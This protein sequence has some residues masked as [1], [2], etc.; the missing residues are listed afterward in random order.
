VSTEF[1]GCEGAGA[2]SW[3]NV[4]QIASG[5]AAGDV[6]LADLNGDKKADYIVVDPAS[7]ATQAWL[8][9]G[10]NPAGGQ[11]IWLPQ[12]TIA[13]GAGLAN[14]RVAFADINADGRADYLAI[15]PDASVD[16]WLNGGRAGSAGR[17]WFWSSQGRIAGSYGPSFETSA[18]GDINGDGRADYLVV[19]LTV[20]MYAYL[21]NGGDTGVIAAH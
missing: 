4:G 20:F 9:G 13:S 10:P 14:K 21:M 5:G 19:D 3:Q 8:N 16:A 12:G 18:F 6:Q 15:S 11:Y 2:W 17:D 7:G 1:L